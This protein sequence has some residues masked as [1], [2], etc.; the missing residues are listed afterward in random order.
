MHRKRAAVA[1]S[2]RRA[3][4]ALKCRDGVWI[5]GPLTTTSQASEP[6]AWDMPPRRVIVTPSSAA[7]AH[8]ASS[9]RLIASVS[10]MFLSLYSRGSATSEMPDSM[11][12]TAE[13][14]AAADADVS[15]TGCRYSSCSRRRRFA[16]TV[17]SSSAGPPAPAAAALLPSRLASS[18][19]MNLRLRVFGACVCL[20]GGAVSDKSRLGGQQGTPSAPPPPPPQIKP[21]S[22]SSRRRCFPPPASDTRGFGARRP[23]S[24]LTCAGPLPPRWRWPLRARTSPSAPP[25]AAPRRRTEGALQGRRKGEREEGRRRRESQ[26][27]V[28]GSVKR[29]KRWSAERARGKKG[30]WGAWSAQ[31]PLLLLSSTPCSERGLPADGSLHRESP[32]HRCCFSSGGQQ[33]RRIQALRKAVRRVRRWTTTAVD[34]GEHTLN[35][36][37]QLALAPYRVPLPLALQ[38]LCFLQFLPVL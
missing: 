26:A 9:R 6:R 25:A 31:S 12:G 20:R 22:S 24:L 38:Q 33:L 8:P 14:P 30:E 5:S 29:N 1:A 4:S 16:S 17:S 28:T 36:T 15:A 23:C 32:T 13:S 11:P 35:A 34:K 10:S 7:S 19:S 21:R 27:A 18:S 3:V 37:H 2:V